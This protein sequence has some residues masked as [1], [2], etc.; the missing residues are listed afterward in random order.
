MMLL[1]LLLAKWMNDLVSATTFA[2]AITIRILRTKMTWQPSFPYLQYILEILSREEQRSI[3]F[4]AD[5][6]W[7]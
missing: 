5:Q 4:S 7:E 6:E 3:I 2:L 1:S